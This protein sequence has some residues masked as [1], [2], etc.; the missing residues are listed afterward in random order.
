MSEKESHRGDRALPH[1]LPPPGRRAWLHTGTVGEVVKACSVLSLCPATLSNTGCSDRRRNITFSLFLSQWSFYT[2]P[3]LETLASKSF[4]SVFGWSFHFEQRQQNSAVLFCPGWVG[5]WSVTPNY[6][7]FFSFFHSEFQFDR[8]RQIM[9]SFFSHN[10]FQIDRWH[11]IM[12]SFFLSP[13]EF[14][15]DRLRQIMLSFFLLPKSFSLISDAKICSFFS[16]F[17]FPRTS[18]TLTWH[19]NQFFLSFFLLLPRCVLFWAVTV[20]TP[21]YF[22]EIFNLLLH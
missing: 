20:I 19:W 3:S 17:F 1:L 13:N 21:E 8:W 18:F 16:S 7:V 9:L 11:Q 4:G 14:Q 5:F 10:E 12:L 22:D 6:V 15:F 2:E